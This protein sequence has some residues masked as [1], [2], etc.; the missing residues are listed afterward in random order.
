MYR[1]FNDFSTFN[2]ALPTD[3]IIMFR[4]TVGEYK[5]DLFTISKV[6]SG[7]LLATPN[8]LF[9]TVSGN[10]ALPGTNEQFPKRSI[11]DACRIA[12]ENPT[13]PYTT[14]VS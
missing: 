6:L 13:A 4:P 2:A 10:D 11:K 3:N 8:V 14:V 12:A 1:S 5:I 7:G 9:V